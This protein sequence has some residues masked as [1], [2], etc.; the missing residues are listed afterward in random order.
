MA[1]EI[2]ILGQNED[3]RG[4]NFTVGFLIP[5]TTRMVEGL[6]WAHT[7]TGTLT[8]FVDRFEDFELE[9]LDDGTLIF[10]TDT[11]YVEGP[12]DRQKLEA[13][14]RVLYEVSTPTVR[15][16][17]ANVGAAVGLRFDAVARR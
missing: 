9:R 4:I 14:A 17:F 8:D 6:P 13:A 2:L 12:Y 5:T 1:K 10:T 7:P 11:I 16:R 3:R 15:E